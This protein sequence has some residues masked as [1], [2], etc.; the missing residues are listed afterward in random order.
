MA[1]LNVTITEDTIYRIQF[2]ELKKLIPIDTSYYEHLRGYE[3]MQEQG[4]FRYL[5]GNSTNIEV[6][7][8][9]YYDVM[10]PRYKGC[11]IVA[12]YQGR[13]VKVIN[14]K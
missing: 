7:K 10:K 13:R 5:I 8:K 4:N 14:P 9:L 3:V 6:I 12:Y 2:Y 1:K 11:F